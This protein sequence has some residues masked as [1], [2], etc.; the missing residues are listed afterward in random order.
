VTS[1]QVA[2]EQEYAY[3]INLR[4]FQVLF[5]R[6]FLDPFFSSVINDAYHHGTLPLPPLEW[7][8]TE[9]WYVGDLV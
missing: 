4:D 7:G 6:D 9:I 5:Q 3:L 8:R 1:A 2:R